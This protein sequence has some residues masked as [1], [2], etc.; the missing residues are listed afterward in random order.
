MRWFKRLG[1]AAGALVALVLLAVS[2]IYGLT[3]TRFRKTYAIS[4]IALQVPTDAA[5][6]AR[7]EHVVKALT[8][9][10]DCHGA[11][12]GGGMVVDQPGVGRIPAPNLTRGKGGVM[13]QHDDESLVRA[14]RYGIGRDGHGMRVMPSAE[15][16]YLS[17]ADLG[18]VIAY[19]KSVP[20]VDREMPSMRIDVI[21]RMLMTAG[22]LDAIAAEVIPQ[23][24]VKHASVPA[25]PTPEYGRYLASIG[26]QGCHGEHFSGGPIPGG[27]PDWAPA[28]NL[29]PAGIGHYTEA[30][31]FR[32]LRDGVKPGGAKVRPPMPI[33]G[34]KQMTDDEIRAVYAY[35][36]T[37]P[38]RE[39]GGR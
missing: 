3:E 23:V 4:G 17:D 29:T 37:V 1:L 38:A 13:A 32:V 30:D 2:A 36:K 33:G 14:I 11:D 6:I 12:L 22:S 19:V 20:P 21:P 18:A 27:P 24:P 31:F 16:R 35:L 10:V 5:S 8:K 26:C 34:T 15:Y 39:F 25:G 28:S 9:C 7:G